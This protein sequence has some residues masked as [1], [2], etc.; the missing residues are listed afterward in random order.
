[1]T[2]NYYERVATLFMITKGVIAPLHQ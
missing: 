1:M 2:W